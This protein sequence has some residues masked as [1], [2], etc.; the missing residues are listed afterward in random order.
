MYPSTI[1]IYA[2]LVSPTQPGTEIKVT[3]DKEAPIMPKATKYQGDCLFPVKKA[4]ASP[5]PEVKYEMRINKMKYPPIMPATNPGCILFL[6][7]ISIKSLYLCSIHRNV[8][9]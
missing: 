9:L 5:L 2:K 3:P 7:S 6:T 8:K 4:L 1:C